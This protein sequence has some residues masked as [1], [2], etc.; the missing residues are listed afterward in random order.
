[1]LWSSSMRDIRKTFLIA[2]KT[3]R[4]G[5]PDKELLNRIVVSSSLTV[6]LRSSWS[7]NLEIREKEVIGKTFIRNIVR[8]GLK[9]SFGRKDARLQIF[10]PILY[11]WR[12]LD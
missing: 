5:H 3:K 7:E 2:V 10:I 8:I 6:I 11:S 9:A 1:M 12:M 4:T